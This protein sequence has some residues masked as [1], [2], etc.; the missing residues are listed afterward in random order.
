MHFPHVIR[1]P[2]HGYIRLTDAEIA[3]IDS[4]EVQRLRQ[5]SQLG[6]TER[7]YPGARHSRFEHALGTLFVATRMLESLRGRYGLEALLT[8]LGVST[9]ETEYQ[10]LL[11]VA[12][13]S[14]LLH[15]I[16]HAPFSHVTEERLPPG[17]THED[18]TFQLI[19]NGDVEGRL[20]HAGQHLA[21]SVTAVL[22]PNAADLPRPLQFVRELLAG[23]IG[24]DRMDYLLRDSAATGVSYGVFDL[25]RVLHTLTP[26]EIDGRLALGVAQ[27][28]EL[29]AEGMLWARFSMFQQVYYHRT[30]RIFDRHLNDYLETMLPRGRYPA[31]LDEYLDWTDARVWE[32][33]RRSLND[34]DLPGHIDADR[35]LNRRHHRSQREELTADAPEP[36]EG[37]LK[38]WGEQ[39]E[40]S[41]PE[42]EPIADLILPHPGIDSGLDLPVASHS[43]Q[44]KTLRTQSHLVGRLT[45]KPMGRMYVAPGRGSF[46]FRV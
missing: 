2:I 45:L 36:L 11:G 30:R 8:P 33:L 3:G 10:Q 19:Q 5:I 16:G 18:L 23:P 40:K 13:W 39:I 34:P 4:R 41:D 28:G 37:W 12:R 42:A 25:E 22:N 9:T 24:A 27:G 1:D 26:V 44:I 46:P 17:S 35:I 14:A 43:G 29:A 15:D 7:V 20:R 31:A 38:Q 21:E 6:L 32:C